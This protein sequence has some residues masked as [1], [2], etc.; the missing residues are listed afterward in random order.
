MHDNARNPPSH[1]R[2]ERKEL[3]NCPEFEC[4]LSAELQFFNYF[5]FVSFLFCS[6]PSIN[7]CHGC[8]L[9][10]C[11][12]CANFFFTASCSQRVS[13]CYA[14]IHHPLH[15]SVGC[16]VRSPD[17]LS[18]HHLLTCPFCFVF[19]LKLIYV[20]YF[21]C[22]SFFYFWKTKSQHFLIINFRCVCDSIKKF[23]VLKTDFERS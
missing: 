17:C 16:Y 9:V 15:C 18:V 13:A 11:C 2:L 23:H 22:Q 4:S 20:C 8:Q 1:Q 19:L 12:A 21:C 14:S 3:V 6:D 10:S 7:N 5:L